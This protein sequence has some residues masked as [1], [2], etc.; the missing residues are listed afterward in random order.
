MLRDPL[1]QWTVGDAEKL[2]N[3]R[4]WGNEYFSIN[5]VGALCVHP[6]R[7]SSRSIDL[8]KLVE[9]LEVRGTDL[10]ILLRF[11]GILRDRLQEIHSA[12]SS[13][14]TDSEYQNQFSCI[15]P[16]KVNQER[17]VVE[18]IV[19]HGADYPCGLEAGSKPELLAVI[20]M[21]RPETLI[22]CNGFKDAGF[23]EA[24]MWA[25][26]LGRRIMPVIERLTE[27]DL[28]LDAARELGVRP[29]VGV[30]VKL[31]ARG[32]GRWKS[33][34]GYRS[35]FGLTVTEILAVV[36][37]LRQRDMLDCLQLIHFHLGSQI[38][39]VQR[40][41]SAVIEATRIYAD[42]VKRGARLKYL[43]VGGGLG[44]DYDG[45]QSNFDS[46][47]N[48]TLAEYA[49]SVV[50]HIG[51]VC[52]DS[53][54]PHPHILAE[55]GRALVAYHTLLVFDVLGVS[56]LGMKT[57]N[58]VA[59]LPPVDETDI[60]LKL[61]RDTHACLNE[62][63]LI[64][65]YHDAQLALDSIGHLFSLGH[66]P[67]DQ[68][69]LAEN[70][71]WRICRRIQQFLVE[72]EEVPDEL[73]DLD[74]V[75]SDIYFCNFSLFQSIP[76]SWAIKQVFP[77]MPI[78]R[79]DER[80]TRHAVLG[81]ITCDS[82]GKLDRFVDNR[83]TR[84]TIPLHQYDGSP[85]YLC[86]AM[87]GAYQ[88]IL[89]DLHNLFGNTNTVHIDLT[90]SGEVTLE[91]IT[92]GDTVREVLEYVH[93]SAEDLV[94]RLQFAVEFAV[95]EG[96]LSYAEAGVLI[97]FFEDGLNGYTYLEKTH[98]PIQLNFGDE[99]SKGLVTQKKANNPET[100]Q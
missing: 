90:A 89:G 41:N 5:E 92:K 46:S 7:G 70:L 43:D 78:H 88:E 19:K 67:L 2:Y 3:V 20:A 18:E 56:G 36:E 64:E 47:V 50:H 99:S 31:A 66:L 26:K 76:D 95:R 42:L 15:Y 52:G 17:H 51:A 25:V 55:C 71:Y 85:Y 86:T 24:A 80:P 23:I 74:V 93:F 68:R 27:L 16:I 21:S 14:I 37:R 8:H 10:P 59:E 72:A 54:V 63:N 81:D 79:L 34:G 60:T 1:Q 83:G 45:S 12:F 6:E 62:D 32:S 49:N 38:T 82:D 13:A 22:I 84:H 11:N 98:V 30:R 53:D 94:A 75:L 29:T 9:R 57:A 28:I 96:R 61:L 97:R 69:A 33:S 77:V 35:K 40:I 87:L 39:D 73:T 65:S 58:S 4:R 91:T 44:V 100:G 48:Y